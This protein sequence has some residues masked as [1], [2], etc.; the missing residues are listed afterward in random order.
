M[1]RTSCAPRWRACRP[2]V[3]AW[4]Q[5]VAAPKSYRNM[6]QRHIDTAQAAITLGADQILRLRHA[7]RR[8]SQLANQ[9]LALSRADARSAQTQPVQRV[10]LQQ[11]CEVVLETHL[12]AATRQGH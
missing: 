7:V 3:E 10:D 9:L 11:L 2:Q 12:D 8:T 6:P 1:Q 4:A 5:A